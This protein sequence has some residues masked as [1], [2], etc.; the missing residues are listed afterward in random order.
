VTGLTASLLEVL[1]R[2]PSVDPAAEGDHRGRTAPDEAAGA[3][4]ER[5]DL[6]LSPRELRV[7]GERPRHRHR[8]ARGRGLLR[9][10]LVTPRASACAED[11]R[12]AGAPLD[13]Y[14]GG[15]RS[16]STACRRARGWPSSSTRWARARAFEDNNRVAVPRRDLPGVVERVAAMLYTCRHC[17]GRGV[18]RAALPSRDAGGAVDAK[19]VRRRARLWPGACS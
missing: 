9:G 17:R 13:S 4:W 18:H 2:R 1:R 6:A 3:E 14:L 10:A 8:S 11:A 5:A 16:P 12:A 19:L 7:E 15:C